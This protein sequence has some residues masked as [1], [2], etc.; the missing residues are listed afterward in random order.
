MATRFVY[1]IRHGQY[2]TDRNYHRAGSLTALGRRQAER[3]GRH[4]RDSGATSLH[5]S[6]MPRAMETAG[7]L[8]PHLPGLELQV[9]S[10]LQEFLPGVPTKWMRAHA[11]GLED[12]EIVDRM[13][14]SKRFRREIEAKVASSLGEEDAAELAG[15]R[16]RIARVFRNYIKPA[17]GDDKTDIVVCH[18]NVIRALFCLAQRVPTEYWLNTMPAHASITKIEVNHSRRFRVLSF[19]ETQ[20]LPPAMRTEQ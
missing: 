9:A 7:I 10:I 3:L 20:H 16:E 15:G 12:A 18:G 6:T 13:R 11:E 1:L 5:A 14:R 2:H 4:L 17:R 19:N 8:A